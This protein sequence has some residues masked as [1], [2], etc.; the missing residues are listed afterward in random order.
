MRTRR[1]ES[2]RNVGGTHPDSVRL[3]VIAGAS[4]FALSACATLGP[5]AGG[6]SVREPIEMLQCGGT[7]VPV[8]ALEEPRSAAELGGEAALALGGREVPALD[9]LDWVIVEESHE[10]VVLIREIVD[11]QDPGV[12]SVG[13]HEV[14][15][16]STEF[17]HTA[18]S[19]SPWGLAQRHSCDLRRHLGDLGPAEVFLDASSPP[20]PEDR[21]LE[22]LVNEYEC[23]SGRDA[24][25]RVE[26]VELTETESAVELV[27]G[28]RPSGALQATCQSNPSTPF[29]VELEHPLGD[30]TVLDAALVPARPVPTFEEWPWV[31]R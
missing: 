22:I 3:A 29:T 17:A 23:N 4:L 18:P 28:V 30:R 19:G 25:G 24:T 16:I 10:Q 20:T 11:P 1:A 5:A 15:V 27:I 14:V 13:K 6:E 21:R 31:D 2:P 7:E 12:G 8:R 26:L 9:P